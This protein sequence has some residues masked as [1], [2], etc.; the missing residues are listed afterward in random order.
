M[1]SILHQ[2][3]KLRALCKHAGPRVPPGRGYSPSCCA[4]LDHS[5]AIIADN[6][7]LPALH[8]ARTREQLGEQERSSPGRPPG[9]W[10]G[11]FYRWLDCRGTKQ[12]ARSAGHCEAPQMARDASAAGGAT[13]GL[14]H[15][16]VRAALSLALPA[17][18]PLMMP[19]ANQ[20]AP[21]PWVRRGYGHNHTIA[22]LVVPR[23]LRLLRLLPAAKGRPPPVAVG[24]SQ[25]GGRVG[26][27]WWRK[28]PQ[29]QSQPQ[30]ARLFLPLPCAKGRRKAGAVTR[31][32]A[33][34]HALQAAAAA[35]RGAG[36]AVPAWHGIMTQ[37]DPRA[38]ARCLSAP[39]QPRAVC[40]AAAGLVPPAVRTGA[41][42]PAS[43]AEP[44]APAGVRA[45]HRPAA[46][47]HQ[48]PGTRVAGLDMPLRLR[49]PAGSSSQLCTQARLQALLGIPTRTLVAKSCLS[50]NA[51]QAASA[52]PGS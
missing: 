32:P 23:L 19:R 43:C 47:W 21:L 16:C 31:A 33:P 24:F 6:G 46:P 41:T 44:V 36:W 1:K 17:G 28:Q 2:K 39:G 35:I 52:W 15:R 14:L 12:E 4:H 10:S 25:E 34:L 29:Y 11:A 13:I 49:S 7:C 42:R 51:G 48:L 5:R 22:A 27:W 8:L 18:A 3:K 40:Q 50:L 26:G 45:R 20:L 30:P 9:R 38:H 37:A